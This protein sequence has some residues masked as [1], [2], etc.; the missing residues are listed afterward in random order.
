MAI[1]N[2]VSNYFWTTFVDSIDFLNDVMVDISAYNR[3]KV[4]G[5]ACA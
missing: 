2:S 5:T 3:I 1:K 4:F